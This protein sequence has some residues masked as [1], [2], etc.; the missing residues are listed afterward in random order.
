MRKKDHFELIKNEEQI[1]DKVEPFYY[2]CLMK[3]YFQVKY[4]PKINKYQK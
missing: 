1:K 3:Y 4:E 2:E